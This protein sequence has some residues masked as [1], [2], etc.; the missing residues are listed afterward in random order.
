MRGVMSPYPA[1]GYAGFCADHRIARR[2][3][4]HIPSHIPFGDSPR[5]RHADRQRPGCFASDCCRL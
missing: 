2:I 1:A 3:A 5:K 4:S